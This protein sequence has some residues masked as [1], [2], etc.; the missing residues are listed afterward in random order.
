MRTRSRLH[1]L[2]G[3]AMMAVLAVV[4][5]AASAQSATPAATPSAGIAFGQRIEGPFDLAPGLEVEYFYFTAGVGETVIGEMKNTGTDVVASPSITFQPL[6]ENGYEYGN[7]FFAL[8]YGVAIQPGESVPFSGSRDD[9]PPLSELASFR[10]TAGTGSVDPDFDAKLTIEGVPASGKLK[11]ALQKRVS[12]RND[13]GKPLKIGLLEAYYAPDGTT[14]GF[15][16]EF[17]SPTPPGKTFSATVSGPVGS[18]LTTKYA[19]EALKLANDAD[20][21]YKLFPYVSTY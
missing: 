5:M 11:D 10:L 15:C 18:C 16:I 20:F 19:M 14:L 2:A 6:D 21:T 8:S 13:S 17:T 3:L 7:S 4:P 1:H 9:N 12:I